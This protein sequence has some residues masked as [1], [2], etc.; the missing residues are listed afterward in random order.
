MRILSES[1][2][3]RRYMPVVWRPMDTSPPGSLSFA[4]AGQ[5]SKKVAVSVKAL[6]PSGNASFSYQ[7]HASSLTSAIAAHAAN[8]ATK[9]VLTFIVSCLSAQLN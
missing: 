5:R 4:A 7:F 6:P 1:V 8:N 2:V 3:K 9:I